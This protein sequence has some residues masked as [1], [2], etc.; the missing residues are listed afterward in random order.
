M[1]K[2]DKTTNSF[3]EVNDP[4]E[5]SIERAIDKSQEILDRLDKLS[6]LAEERDK[7]KEQLIFKLEHITHR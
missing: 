6:K 4:L 5:S 1:L 3:V 7:I 2:F